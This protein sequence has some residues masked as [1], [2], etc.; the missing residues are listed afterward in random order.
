M[1][2]YN[3]V[4]LRTY[5]NMTRTAHSTKLISNLLPKYMYLVLYLNLRFYLEHGILWIDFHRVLRFQESRSLAPYIEKNSTLLAAGK[6]EFEKEFF[7]LMNNCIYGKTCQ[8]YKKRSD[9]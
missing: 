3:Q 6:N 1:L 2:S 5:Y 4:E 8:N 7:K 9:S